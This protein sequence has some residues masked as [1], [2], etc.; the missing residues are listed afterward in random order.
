MRIGMPQSSPQKIKH[1]LV[2]IQKKGFLS[3]D[4]ARGIMERSALEPGWSGGFLKEAARLFSIPVIGATSAG[5]ASV[6]AEQNFQGILRISCRL[7]GRQQPTGLY[8][9]KV[10]GS[11]MNRATIG[12]KT[13]EDGDYVIIDSR[14][15]NASTGDVVLALIDGKATIKRLVDDR[16]NGQI[17]LRADSSF[18]YE[19]IY[20][21]PEDDFAISGKVVSVVKRPRTVR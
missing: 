13:I 7:V 2:Q 17:V 4:R 19:P 1:H 9:L 16:V 15:K 5:P 10:D 21:H 12:G 6:F 8:A 20:L 14:D 18:D 11:S 3:I